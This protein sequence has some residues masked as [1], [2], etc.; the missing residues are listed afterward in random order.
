M[1]K[2]V[3]ATMAVFMLLGITMAGNVNASAYSGMNNNNIA[4]M[5]NMKNACGKKKSSMQN[6]GGS[7]KMSNACGKKKS[8]T[9]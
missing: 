7:K 1:K 2:L 4:S 9:M 3:L 5:S 6:S 8:S